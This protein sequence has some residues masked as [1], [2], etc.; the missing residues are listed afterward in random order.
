MQVAAVDLAHPLGAL[1]AEER[2]HQVMCLEE[3]SFHQLQVNL[4]QVA[5]VVVVVTDMGVEQ[6]LLVVQ[7]S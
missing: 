1:A 3:L 4:I 6:A 5:A 2:V 7:A